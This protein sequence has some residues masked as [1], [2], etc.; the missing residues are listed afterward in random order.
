MKKVC[1]VTASRAE[2]GLLR[3]LIDEI[4]NDLE[5]ELQLIVTGSHLSNEHGNTYREIEKDGYHINFRV[6]MLLSSLTKSGIAKSMG[7][8]SIGIA[9]AFVQ[10]NPDLLIVLGDR[11]ELLP[12]CSTALVMNIPIAHISGGD[13]T[14]GAIDDQI[15]NAVTMLSDIH[16]PGVKDSADRII[17]MRGTSENVFIVGEPGLDNF[18]RLNLLD[19]DL[20][21]GEL[22]IDKEK[23]WI[24][25]TYHPET[26]ITL[27][28]NLERVY[29]IIN[30][31]K[32]KEN[33]QVIIT[34]SNADFGGAEINN[35]WDSISNALPN[36]FKLF[37]SL[38]QLNYLSIMKE[39]YCIIGNS[40]SGIIEAP[41]LKKPVINIGDRQ[42]GRYLCDNVFT[43]SG[44]INTLNEGFEKVVT[45]YNNNHTISCNYYGDGKTSIKIKEHIKNLFF[46]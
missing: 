21:S 18:I 30:I 39:S 27:E 42:T 38:G 43:V 17:R 35:Y 34:R 5:L 7:V 36:K 6:E 33:I 22:K 9:D 37:D 31:L 15:R 45:F 16:F 2:Y 12:I 29:D 4:Q 1:V 8:C 10:L 40:S 25:L 24:L 44:A 46:S 20:L 19:R 23:N 28:K 11:Y 3:W 41:F 14:E 13:I 32:E 26:K